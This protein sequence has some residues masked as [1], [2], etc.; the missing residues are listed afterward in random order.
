MDGLPSRGA[1]VQ[2]RKGVENG[3]SA[4]C[5]ETCLYKRASKKHDSGGNN[6]EK[7]LTVGK[8]VYSN[9]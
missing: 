3:A 1:G 7:K 5:M 6:T 2:P 8:P 9:H 4:V